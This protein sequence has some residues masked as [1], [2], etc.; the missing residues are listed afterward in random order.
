MN[1]DVFVEK[2]IEIFENRYDYKYLPKEFKLTD[3]IDILYL[4]LIFKQKAGDH[5][6]GKKPEEIRIRNTNDFVN[7]SKL[8]WGHNKYD[9]S[10][11][12][13]TS[14]RN[15]VKIIYNGKI[16]N[17]IAL[18]HLNG[19]KCENNWDTE[20][21][22]TES[23]KIFK[24]KYDYSLVEYRNFQ[25]PVKIIYNGV[26]YEQTPEKHLRGNKVENRKNSIKLTKE[27]FIERSD[28]IFGNKYDY[29][30]VDYINCR[31]PVK[32]IYDGIIYEQQPQH[33]LAGLSPEGINIIDT[34][35]FIKKSKL[36]FKE[37]YD[38]SLVDYKDFQTPIKIIYNGQVY[39][40][41]PYYHLRGDRPEKR[42]VK[43]TTNEFVAQSN[44]IH[45]FRYLYDKTQYV[46][47]TS[48]VIITCRK[49]G[50]FKQTPNSH[51]MGIGCPS[52]NESKAESKI[53]IALRKFN[54]NFD[55]QKKFSGCRNIHELPFDFY[56]PSLRVCIEFD[57]KQHFEPISFFGGLESFEKLKINDKIKS[58]YCEDNYID[59]IR[60]KYDQLDNIERIL[61]DNLKGK[62][63][64]IRR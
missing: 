28:K 33:H 48:K 34:E 29:S 23:K 11:T 22:I 9:Y 54:I 14:I 64:S 45:E 20:K 17:Q 47:S 60:I 41:K 40:Q 7:K 43:K 51:L 46:L 21:F 19:S 8:L 30:L 3:T 27:K 37:R 25:T 26:I 12:K 24:S 49:H 6:N 16:Y 53:S 62:I 18:N 57:G 52:C 31:T 44:L 4:G 58:D 1:K 59:L 35:S 15:K 32:I 2:S 50:D 42:R 39:F 56:I 13:Y 61:N 38:Y 10:L 63:E 36:I 55:R 5:L